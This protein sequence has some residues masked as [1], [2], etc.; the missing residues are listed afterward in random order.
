MD[1]LNFSALRSNFNGFI[2]IITDFIGG[3]QWLAIF[4][5]M[6]VS[7]IFER[8]CLFLFKRISWITRKTK[9]DLD[10]HIIAK[11]SRPIGNYILLLGFYIIIQ[12]LKL[13]KAPVDIKSII[14]TGIKIAVVINTIWLLI[15]LTDVL[16]R[17]L[18]SK[19]GKTS[20]RLDD[21]LIPIF[22]KTVKVF[23]YI[24]GF[25]Y[26]IQAF[27]Y[28]ISGVLAGLGIG[29]LAVALAAKDTLANLFGSI[30]LIT[31]R[32][33]R[34]GDWIRVG[35]DEG[36]VEQ[37]GFRSTRIRT[38]P[39]TQITIP[40][41]VIAN[42]SINNFS[43]MPK[44]RVK[45]TVGVTYETTADQMEVVVNKIR[46]LLRDHPDV[47]P[48][49]F[50]VNFTDFGGS[51]LDILVYYFTK[52]TKWAHYLQVRQEINLSIMRVIEESGLSIAF[53][54][55]TVYLKSEDK[56]GSKVQGS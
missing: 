51:S 24:L 17:Y 53:P 21:Q 15:R 26:I 43:R 41:S 16:G 42:T 6:L 39:K 7:F 40:N 35:D 1:G 32:P 33:F 3:Q 29:G 18:F 46:D 11:A 22:Q 8:I 23:L 19:A 25:I 5:V 52:S 27:G 9:T 12:I 36:Y 47:D 49:F 30:T 54:T 2:D 13:P 45:M 50:M 34:V 55:R 10:D 20:S 14:L 44:R 48:E 56:E 28:S 4:L 31:D 37:I 38:F